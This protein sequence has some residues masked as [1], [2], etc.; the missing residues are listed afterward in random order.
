VAATLTRAAIYARVS[1]FDQ[2]PENQLQ[3]LR[4][5]AQARGWKATEYVDKG[6]SGAKDSR[7]ALDTLVRDAKRRRFDT[8]VVWRLDRLGRNLKHLVGLLDDLQAL[9]VAFVSLA[10]G[11]DATTPAGRL[12]MHILG[13]IADYAEPA[14]MQRRTAGAGTFPALQ[15]C[16]ASHYH[17]ACSDA[18]S[19]SGALNRPRRSSG[20]STASIASS[21]SDG[22]TRR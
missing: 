11:I 15:W 18:I 1:T 8:L 13:A 22:S 4:R 17:G 9:D 5:Y 14:V 3:E 6:V 20:G 10:E 21:F 7:P 12:Q 2:E 19:A 16:G